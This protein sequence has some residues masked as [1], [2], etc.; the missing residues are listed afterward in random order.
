MSETLR[1]FS[2]NIHKGFSPGN[3]RYLLKEIRHAI[4]LVNADLLFLQE[5]I[6]ENR[7]HQSRLTNWQ[8]RQ[9]EYLADEIWHHK[10]YGKNA[11]YQHGHH[12]NAI[13]SKHPFNHWKNFDISRWWFSQRGVLHGRLSNG[14]NV[15]C[16]H[17]GL[18]SLERQHQAELLVELIDSTAKPGEPLIIAGDMNDWRAK[19]HRYLQ[20]RL[21]V[22]EIHQQLNGKPA[23]TFPAALPL[24]R[25]DRIYYRGLELLDASTL[26]EDHWRGLSDHCA[27]YCEFQLP[28]NRKNA[29]AR[30][31]Q[32][33]SK[34]T[35]NPH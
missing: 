15:Y 10:A 23:R 9:F 29:V 19:I 17:M 33:D 3:A 6:G 24:L 26:V 5:V 11:I 34:S 2:Y 25:M 14:L 8:D 31:S 22:K 27:L 7:K 12:G 20:E 32:C 4:R 18:F 16:V 21:A 1:V 28:E 30:A 13:L 35:S